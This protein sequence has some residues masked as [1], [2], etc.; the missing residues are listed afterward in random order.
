MT[1][2]DEV[3]AAMPEAAAEVAYE[4]LTIDPVT[5]RIIVPEAEGDLR[6]GRRWPV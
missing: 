3:L 5:R 6:R 2:I 1:T 4:Y